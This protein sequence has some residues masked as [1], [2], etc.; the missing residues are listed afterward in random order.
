MFRS[1]ASTA[2]LPLAHVRLATHVA[3]CTAAT[4]LS[5]RDGVAFL[6][7]SAAVGLVKSGLIARIPW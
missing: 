6:L 5:K 2:S 4:C 7:A 3:W 1:A